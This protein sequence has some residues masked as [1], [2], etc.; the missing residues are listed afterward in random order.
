MA[1]FVQA[2]ELPETLEWVNSRDRVR[3]SDMLGRV[4]I[5]YF[6]SYSNINSINAL[7]DIRYLQGKYHDGL[8]VVGLHCPKFTA[9][10]GAAHVLKAVNRQQIRFPVASD[11]H[12]HAWQLYSIRAWPSIVVIDAAGKIAGVFSGEDRRGELDVMVGKLLDEAVARDLRAF[13]AAPEALRPEPKMPLRFPSKLVAGEHHLYLADSGHHR[14]LEINPDGTVDRTFGSGNPGFWDGRMLDAAF[15]NPGGM[16]IWKDNLYVADTGNHSIRRIRLASAEVET[17]AGN[18]SQGRL[19]PLEGA[20]PKAIGLNAPTDVVATADMLY[21]A[22]AGQHQ[23]WTYDIVQRRLAVFAGSGRYGIDD[24]SPDAATFAK[25]SALAL[26]GGNLYVADADGS[27]IRQIRLSDGLVST[28]VGVGLYD[29]GDV[30]GVPA[31]VRMQHPMALAADPSG[32]LLWL[33]DSYNGKLKALSLK[34]GGARTLR[35]QRRFSEPAGMALSNGALWVADTN[36][37][38]LIRLDTKSGSVERIAV[39]E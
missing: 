12:F 23:I 35:L 18:G 2:P 15:F 17:V 16:A 6:W 21:I 29:F 36:A 31:Q 4:V 37:H 30:D 38:E 10:R 26:N 9:E 33:A 25:P 27:A 8:N 22:M 34:G 1:G 39:G 28:L 32:A 7:A 3:L 14:I 20:D 13:G 5:L 11:P 24:G 19:L